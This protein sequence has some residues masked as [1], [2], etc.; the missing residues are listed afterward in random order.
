MHLKS[1]IY[2]Y[3]MVV[4]TPTPPPFPFQ[5]HPCLTLYQP[6][7]RMGR[8]CDQVKSEEWIVVSG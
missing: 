7:P 6:P 5:K 3:N 1:Y 2:G 8:L 4:I